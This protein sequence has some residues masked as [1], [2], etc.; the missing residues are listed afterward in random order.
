MSFPRGSA[1][2]R[3]GLENFKYSRGQTKV[4]DSDFRASA[5]FYSI[6]NAL[7]FL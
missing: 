3:A 5:I 1:P 6:V 7:F 2:P 4:I